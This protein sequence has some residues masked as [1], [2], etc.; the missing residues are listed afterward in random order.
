MVRGPLVTRTSVRWLVQFACDKQHPGVWWSVL[1]TNSSQLA[2]AVCLWRRAARW[3]VQ[4]ACDKQQPSGW[5]SLLVTNSSQVADAVCLWQTAA[6]WLVQFACD[7]QQ[8]GDWCSL[9]VTN[10]SQVARIVK[11]FKRLSEEIRLITNWNEPKSSWRNRNK[12]PSN[13]EEIFYFIDAWPLSKC[14]LKS[15]FQNPC[16]WTPLAHNLRP[17]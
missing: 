12:K 7:K 8:P 15:G 6:R 5:Y 11:G 1:V 10:S 9:F 14:R 2:G 3:L 4:F 17:R 16:S 13:K